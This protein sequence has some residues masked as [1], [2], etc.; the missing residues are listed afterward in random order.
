[1]HDDSDPRLNGPK[2]KISTPTIFTSATRGIGRASPSSYHPIHSKLPSTRYQA[3]EKAQRRTPI[4]IQTTMYPR[5]LTFS[6]VIL[7]YV[8]WVSAAVR[9]YIPATPTN[10]TQSAIQNGLN[11]TE[12]STLNVLWYENGCV[13][14]PFPGSLPVVRVLNPDRPSGV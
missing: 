14:S 11:T 5:S 8:P 6:R 3:P 12:A 1:M 13:L 2:I 7:F 4:S 9:A 10:D